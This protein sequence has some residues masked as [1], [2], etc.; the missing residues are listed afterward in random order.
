[1]LYP[2]E[3]LSLLRDFHNPMTIFIGEPFFKDFKTNL[4]AAGQEEP[5]AR[6]LEWN[7]VWGGAGQTKSAKPVVPHPEAAYAMFMLESLWKSD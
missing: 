4:V 1:M 3:Q 5:P 6:P 7:P 2:V